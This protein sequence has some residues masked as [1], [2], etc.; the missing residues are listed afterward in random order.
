MMTGRFYIDGEDAYA[1]YGVYVTDGGLNSVIAY[2]PGKAPDTNDWQEDDGVEADLADG[3][4]LDSRNVSL[5][6]ACDR[7]TNGYFA[8]L[9]LL[10]DKQEHEFDFKGIGRTYRLRLKDQPSAFSYLRE[11][12]LFTLRFTDDHPA[13]YLPEESAGVSARHYDYI[14]LDGVPFTDMGFTVLEG[15]TDDVLKHSAVKVPLVRD[16][17]GMDGKEA[18][19]E[20][21]VTFKTRDVKITCHIHKPLAEL[22]TAYDGLLCRLVR[23]DERMLDFALPADVVGCYYKSCS[24]NE[25][26]PDAGRAWLKFTVTF[27]VVSGLRPTDDRLLA[28]EDGRWV[29]LEDAPAA[30]ARG[31]IL[32]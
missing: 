8:L 22:W 19:T 21:P 16:I 13:A 7:F 23:P 29:I 5:P 30:T 11:L 18:D 2:P 26:V 4:R 12:A 3:I 6:L 32:V 15:S 1:K 20:A 31:Y 28:T 27:T 24:V 9:E 10:A 14:E 17:K 25:F